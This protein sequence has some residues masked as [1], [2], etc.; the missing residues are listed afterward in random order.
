MPSSR[1]TDLALGLVFVFGVT[2]ALASVI[3]ELIARFLGLRAT[4]LLQGLRE[5]LDG[6][7]SST[8]A[9]AQVK[10]DYAST[11]NLVRSAAP[12]TRLVASPTSSAPLTAAPLSTAASATGALLGSPILRNQGLAGQLDDR[13]LTLPAT[14]AVG[15]RSMT[16]STPGDRM[17]KQ[18]RSLPAYIPARSFSEAVLDL[19]VPNA[20]GQ[21]TMDEIAASV[22]ALP[23]SMGVFKASLGSL[24]KSAG[25]DVAAFR[26]SVEHWYDDHMSRVSGW[27]KRHVAK[28]T[29]VVGAVL[30]LLVNI[31]AATIGRTLYTDNDVRAAVSAVAATSTQCPAGQ[32]QPTCLKNLE[33]QLSDASSAGLPLGWATVDACVGASSGCDWLDQRGLF[34]HAGGSGWQLL[35]VLVGFA[36]TIM[37]LVPGARFWFDLL[38]RLG[39]LRSTGPPPSTT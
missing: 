6:S 2:A 30:V 11:V 19:L 9:L 4:Y 29:L 33:Q 31:N 35:L 23:D 7:S 38:G 34:N 26:T 20:S 28:I 14:A 16:S 10:D 21:T 18:R 1:I 3:T 8:M 27:Y 32:D 12:A 25:D 5:L 13:S 17:R 22:D 24:V 36:L 37:A 15:R 39:S